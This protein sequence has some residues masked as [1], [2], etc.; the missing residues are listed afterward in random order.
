MILQGRRPAKAPDFIFESQNFPATTALVESKGSFVPPGKGTSVKQPLKEGLQ[1]IAGWSRCL[2]PSPNK[3][4]VVGSFIREDGDPHYEPSLIAFVDPEGDATRTSS[5]SFP[6]DSIRIG[7][8]AAWLKGMGFVQAAAAL[9]APRSSR[10][11][12][13]TS[14]PVVTISGHDY[15]VIP[16]FAGWDEPFWTPF[17]SPYFDPA[18]AYD[19]LRFTLEHRRVEL[20]VMGLALSVFRRISNVLASPGSGLLDL[21]RFSMAPTETG[22]IFNDGTFLGILSPGEESMQRLRSETLLL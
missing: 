5:R 20:P 1:Q 8:Y 12:R 13:E 11:L 21:P 6:E 17:S 14:L 19:H 18:D 4:F 2:L 3:G 9:F 10:N 15:V 7:N 22:S 16:D